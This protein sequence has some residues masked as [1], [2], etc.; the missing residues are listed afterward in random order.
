L[1]WLINI[2]IFNSFLVH[3]S[4]NN[5]TNDIRWSCHMRYNDLEDKSF[6]DRGY[7]NPYIYKPIDEYM[8]P[9]FNTKKVINDYFENT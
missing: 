4:G 8:T 9:E 2:K 7:P 1:D 6:K 3:K 5:I